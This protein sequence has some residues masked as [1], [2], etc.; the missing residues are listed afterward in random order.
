M[1]PEV[2]EDIE[3]LLEWIRMTPESA[4]D[5]N[6]GVMKAVERVESYLATYQDEKDI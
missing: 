1:K 6:P 3:F 4:L 2:A 5:R